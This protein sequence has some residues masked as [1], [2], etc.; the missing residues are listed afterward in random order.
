MMAMMQTIREIA[1]IVMNMG[2]SSL[3]PIVVILLSLCFGVKAGKAVYSGLMIGAGF[4][5]I[6]LIVGM[7]NNGLGMAA[8]DMSERF[9]LTLSVVDIGWQGAAPMA[10]SSGIAAAAI[11]IA[12]LVNL[13]MLGCGLTRTVNID[14]WNI[15]HMAFTGALAYTVTGNLW[16]GALGVAVHAVV[17]YKLGDLWAPYIEGYFELQGLTVP[18]GTAAYMAPIACL[19][20]FIIEKIPGINR[21]DF[22]MERLQERAGIF[23]EPVVIGGIMGSS[24]GILA[25]YRMD[26][27]FPLGIQM[28]AVMVLMPK[29]VKCIMEG[30][31]PLS[32]GIKRTLAKR[33]AG[34]KFYIALD[35]AVLLGD[36]Q[37]VT[38]GL[39]FIPL[40]LLIAMVVPGN[41][42][43]PFGDLATISFFIAIAVAV[44]QGN[45]FR[46]LVSGSVIMYLT[47]WIANQTVP[48][49]TELGKCSGTIEGN[50]M[51]AAL[52]QGGSP[53]TYLFVRLFERENAD[54]LMVVGVLYLVSVVVSV[55]YSKHDSNRNG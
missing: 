22:S 52:D 47:I 30:L 15:W 43:L 50:R 25:G 2:A 28:A 24:I 41:R 7:M 36:S 46:T 32:E 35:P 31:L 9:G 16:I 48:W 5:G 21:I 55:Y 10:W 49:V 17:V 6:S 39:L 11:P 14:I 26:K 12:V 40:T 45:L 8:Q 23:A 19:V 20:D 3:L 37:V 44:H 18:H 33:F 4:A 13:V 53:V 27:A 38:A 51:A 29:I 54:G 42:V 1:N 34:G